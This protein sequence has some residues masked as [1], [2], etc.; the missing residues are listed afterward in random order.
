MKELA[1]SEK[2]YISDTYAD[3]MAVYRLEVSLR[4]NKE[5]STTINSI[6]ENR[7]SLLPYEEN[8]E[9]FRKFVMGIGY[10][11]KEREA[12]ISISRRNENA[13]QTSAYIETFL[14]LLRDEEILKEI[15]EK[16]LFRLVHFRKRN[17]RE[18]FDLIPLLE[19]KLSK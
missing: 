17:N 16:T 4:T 15:H 3:W 5:I 1:K 18:L 14:N 10:S 6:V 12:E 9:Q 2:E 7:I 11:A 8:S 19:S 13:I